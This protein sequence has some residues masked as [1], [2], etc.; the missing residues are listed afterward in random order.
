MCESIY[1]ATNDNIPDLDEPTK[2]YEYITSKLKPN[3]EK[4]NTIWRSINSFVYCRRNA[5]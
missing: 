2:L 4:K 5:Y 3:I 1:A